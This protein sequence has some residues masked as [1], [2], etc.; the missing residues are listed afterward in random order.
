MDDGLTGFSGNIVRCKIFFRILG[1]VFVTEFLVM[2]SLWFINMP[3]G[4]PEFILDSVLLSLLSAPFLYFSV[5]RVVTRRLHVE[6]LHTQAAREKELKAE[7]LAETLAAKA[8]ADNIVKSVHSGLVVV[9]GDFTVFRVNPAFC[10]MFSM[11]PE[12]AEGRKIDDVLAFTDLKDAIRNA[13]NAGNESEDNVFESSSQGNRYFR[14]SVSRIRLSEDD[15]MES[16]ALLVIEDV[17]ER[18][19]SE[20]KIIQLANYDNLTGLPNRRLLMNYLTQTISLVGRRALFAAVLFIDLDRFK[21]INDTLGHSAGDELLREVAERLK[22]CVRLSDTVGRLGGDEFIV[23]LPDIEQIDDITIICSRIYLIFETPVR[24]E[25]HEVSVMLSIGISVYPTDGVDAETLLRKADVAMYRAKSDGKSCH[26]FYSEGMGQ[27]GADRLRLESRMRRAAE[28]GELHLNYQPQIDIGTGIMYGAEA[29]LRW[30]DPEYGI[31]SPKEFIPIAEECGLIIPV[32]EWLL[33]RACSQARAWQ[34]KG[35]NHIRL[36]VNIS[37][38]QFMQKE[39]VHMVDTILKETGLDP[40]FLELELTES[41]IMANAEAI[42]RILH[43]LK[44]TGVRLSIDD[45]GT[46]YSSIVCLKH[47]PIDIIKIDQSFVRDM[48][49]DRDYAAICDAIIRLAASLDIDVIAEGVE[50]M[51][52][53]ELLRR[54]D[55]RNIQ[56]YIVSRPMPDDDFEVFLR[57]D[58]VFPILQKSSL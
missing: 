53:L 35:L 39:F 23:L 43:E 49:V 57:K 3:S 27:S 24:C 30:H 12:D 28:R 51:E 50:T 46:G 26:R 47:M 20:E 8:Y 5:V 22:K 42:V 7:S 38:R 25:E 34:D 11:D 15:E 10:R 14:I 9:S 52:Q 17:T 55:C 1:I 21:L 19:L 6:A 2:A 40:R 13:F 58:W 16:Q 36:A 18:R 48:T 56:G 31:I 37:L 44:D 32:G 4:I 54:L 29:L 41:V 33:R 45:F